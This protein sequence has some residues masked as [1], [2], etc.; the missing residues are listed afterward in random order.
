VGVEVISL[1][2]LVV[3]ALITSDFTCSLEMHQPI[4]SD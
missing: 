2:E 4:E 1:S 3:Q